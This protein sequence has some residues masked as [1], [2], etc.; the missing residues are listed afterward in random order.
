MPGLCGK[1]RLV[2]G[3]A[4]G[5]QHFHHLVGGGGGRALL[6]VAG[7]HKDGVPSAY[8]YHAIRAA[9]GSGGP[10]VGGR[11]KALALLAGIIGDSFLSCAFPVMSC[12]HT[13]SGGMVGVHF[14][15]GGYV[16][17]HF[18]NEPFQPVRVF[19]FQLRILGFSEENIFISAKQG[20]SALCCCP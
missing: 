12:P 7:N 18:L 11:S 6:E 16:L 19:L 3:C 20:G 13:D 14:P 2:S 5:F 10:S 8:F 4:F 15:V 1:R 17:A 9:G